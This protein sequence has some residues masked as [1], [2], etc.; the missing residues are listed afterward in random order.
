MT[1]KPVYI[2]IC[3]CCGK[4]ITRDNLST[5]LEGRV[6]DW[7][8]KISISGVTYHFCHHCA[9]NVK[10]YLK[11]GIKEAVKRQDEDLEVIARLKAL[12]DKDKATIDP[13]IVGS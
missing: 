4:P 5:S 2:G 8:E 1:D 3:I 12:D 6:I 11:G 13:V 10:D 7:N 9:G